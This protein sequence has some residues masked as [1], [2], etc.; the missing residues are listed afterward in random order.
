MNPPGEPPPS[1]GCSL[2]LPSDP[3]AAWEARRSLTRDAELI[4]ES[5]LH[6]QLLS[7]ATCRQSF[8]SVFSESVDWADGDDPQYWCLVPLSPE[9]AVA[10]PGLEEGN[11]LGAI[12]SAAAAREALHRD[13]PKGSP[14]RVFWSRG[15]RV[16]S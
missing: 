14:T 5:H 3:A 16:L 9:A 4:D 13:A 7:C 11:L 15:L 10:L 8:A 2:C 6:V 12:A 1:A